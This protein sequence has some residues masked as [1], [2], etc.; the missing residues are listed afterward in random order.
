[1]IG[2]E[3]KCDLWHARKDDAEWMF[4]NR[5]RP[6]LLACQRACTLDEL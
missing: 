6:G 3:S 2:A 4:G 5:R 1:V